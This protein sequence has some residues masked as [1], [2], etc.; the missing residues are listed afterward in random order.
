M[1]AQDRIRWDKI[2]ASRLQRDYPPPDP[3]LFDFTPRVIEGQSRRALDLAGGVGQNALWLATQ[4]YIVDL[5]D[6]SRVAL[7]RASLEIINRR[8]HN[9]NLLQRDLEE[10]VPERA[11]Y[12]LV[13]VFRYLQRANIPA[14]RASV[15][16]GGRII[17]ATFN[18]RHLADKPDAN[19]EYLLVPGELQTFFSDWKV[20][21]L[22]ESSTLSQIVVLKPG[23]QTP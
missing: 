7:N 13:C 6:I 11:R 4:G 17:Y 20:V 18:Q 22:D 10:Y 9:I 1:S 14:L 8:L 2:Y 15:V 16:D 19:P 5:I 3:L 23:A 21:Y 12:D